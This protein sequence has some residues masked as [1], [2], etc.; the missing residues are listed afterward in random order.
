[1]ARTRDEALA[2]VRKLLALAQSDNEHEAAAAMARAQTIMDR[3]K[4]EAAMIDAT[5]DDEPAEEID[6][7][8]DPIDKGGA[9]WRSRLA[10][11]LGRSNGC[12]VYKSGSPLYIIGKA[13]SVQ[14]VRYLL[15]Y[16]AREIDRLAACKR[17]NGR[18]WLNNYRHGCVDAVSLAL[19]NEA[20]ALRAN[21]RAEAESA[22]TALAR[23]DNALAVVQR[24]YQEAARW[25]RL[26][27]GLRNRSGSRSRGNAS[28][29]AAG[30]SD[31]SGI[32]PGGGQRP[33]IGAGQR[34]IGG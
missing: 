16:C 8:E 28:A 27:L 24:D 34:R 33:G 6:N 12:Q 26:H 3:H 23:I 30:R 18:T 25:G 20:A 2:Q 17:G 10:Q 15:D 5:P 14:T 7:W 9:A 19:D 22:G 1:M 13:S 32:Y 31:G 4:I 21:M 29:R 11:V